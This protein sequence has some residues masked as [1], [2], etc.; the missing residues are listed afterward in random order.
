MEVRCKINKLHFGKRIAGYRRKAGLSQVDLAEK[1][2]I[3]SLQLLED[4]ME[5]DALYLL[6]KPEVSLSLE[7]QTVLAEK[8]NKL[9]R[10]LG[11]QFIISTHSPFMHG[12]LHA[13]IYNLDSRD[14]EEAK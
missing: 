4:Y 1:L 2:G 13:K 5:P 14:L 10:F 11:C 8:L 12:T 9:A 7:N 3:T 6:D